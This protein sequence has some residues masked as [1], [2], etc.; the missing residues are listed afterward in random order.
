MIGDARLPEDAEWVKNRLARWPDWVLNGKSSPSGRFTF[1]HIR[2]YTKD[3]PLLS[4]GLLGPVRLR[5]E[6]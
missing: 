6:R 4:S 3:S 5:V 1:T 2:P